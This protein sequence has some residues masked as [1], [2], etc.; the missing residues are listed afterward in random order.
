MHSTRISKRGCNHHCDIGIDALDV[1]DCRFRKSQ[2]CHDVQKLLMVDSIDCR[3]EV[4]VETVQVSMVESCVFDHQDCHLKLPGC[5]MVS[6]KAFLG[7]ANNALTF[8]ICRKN[9]GDHAGPGL[10]ECVGQSL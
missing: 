6:A 7:A 4:N 1:P 5:I 3:G 8:P 2:A 9:K 10:V